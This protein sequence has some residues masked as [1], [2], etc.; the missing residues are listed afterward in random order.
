MEFGA[1]RTVVR[2]ILA[3][4]EDVIKR[5]DLD[6]AEKARTAAERRSAMLETMQPGTM[7]PYVDGLPV[8]V[9]RRFRPIRLH[10]LIY[11][12]RPSLYRLPQR[13]S[14]RMEIGPDT[15]HQRHTRPRSPDRVVDLRA[16][17][18][19]ARDLGHC[20]SGPCG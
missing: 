7:R 8:A 12:R 13:S 17:H 6:K 4:C 18:L 10:D 20:G 19:A 5:G 16:N 3:W 2:P 9:A 1:D 15:M 11:G 14:P